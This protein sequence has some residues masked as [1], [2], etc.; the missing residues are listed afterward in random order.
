M[1]K[2][3][4][5]EQE[6][7]VALARDLLGKKIITFFNNQKTSGIIS[8]TEAYR[9]PE[10]RGS[11][12]FNNRKTPRTEVMF[13]SGGC[14]Y[15]YL[16][17]G[18]HHLT[19]IVTGPEGT[20][21]AILIRAIIPFDGKEIMAERRGK[22]ASFKELTSGPGG[23][24]IALGLTKEMSGISLLGPD[25]WLEE[26]LVYEDGEILITPRI[27]LDYAGIDASNLWRF[28]VKSTPSSRKKFK[29]Y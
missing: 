16:C 1:L 2:Q 25:L 5:F 20:A 14:A 24:S 15:I 26:H 7:V 13:R 8:E 9:A 17:Y 19:N 28:V 23:V 22:P 12:A 4:Y 11:H 3:I 21:H 10:D 18:I 27:G 29:T 6:D